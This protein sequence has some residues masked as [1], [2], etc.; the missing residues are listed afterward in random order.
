MATSTVRADWRPEPRNPSVPPPPQPP[1]DTKANGNRYSLVQRAHCLA[2]LMEGYSYQEIE[3]KTGIKRST[4]ANIKTRAYARGFCPEQDPRILECHVEDSP[5]SGR[6]KEISAATEQRLL[7]S[8]KIDRAGREKSSE[9]LAYENAI[10]RSSALR[11]LHSSGLSNVKPTRKPGLNAVQRASRLTFCLEHK[12]WTLEDWKRVIWSD[13]TSVILGQ[14]RGTVR[15]W[16]SSNEAYERTCIRRRWKGYSEFMF[17]GCFSWDKKGPCYIWTKETAQQRQE[18]EKELTDLNI[19]LEPELKAKWELANE[20]RRLNLRQRP[21][22]RKAQ[23]RF[24]KKNGKLV[25]ESKAGGI[26]WY[27]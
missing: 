16:R 12:D 21:P 2:L 13:E 9:V 4:Q 18:A 20:M 14:R 23:W 1:R 8:I 25:R 6:P 19:A 24:T 3:R 27:R 15:L 26:D 7:D 22:G 17:W 10:S 5:R 11:I